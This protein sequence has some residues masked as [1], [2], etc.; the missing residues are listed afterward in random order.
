MKTYVFL[1]V[2][3]A[4]FLAA[5]GGGAPP[6][7]SSITLT[8][9]DPMGSF[10][11]A[12]YQV[13][14]GPWQSLT[15]SGMATK[16][17]TFGLGAQ[18]QYGVAVRCSGLVVKVIQATASE[19]PN[20]KLEC[21][22]SAPSTVPFTVNVNV[23][24]SLLAPGDAVCVHRP[25]GSPTCVPAT[26]SSSITCH[27]V[28]GSQDFLVSLQDS[29]G[30]VKVAK[31]LRNVVVNSGGNATV[32]LAPGDQLPPVGLTLPTPPTGYAPLSGALVSY[33]SF[34]NTGGGFVN[35]SL[36]SYRPVSGFSTGDR[37]ATLIQTAATNASLRSIQV[38]NSGS[39]S[40]SLPAPWAAG[41]LSVNQQAHPTVNGL[42]RSDPDLRGYE[43]YLQIAGQIY[44]TAILT[45]DWLGSTTSYTFPDLSAS[46]LLGYTPP[47]GSGSLKIS[48]NWSN[49]N[50]FA[51]NLTNFQAGDY[52]KVAE[53]Q[54]NYT[55]GG[56]TI[57]LP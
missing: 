24:A 28:S 15:M 2:L 41:S 14:S 16:T 3:L 52:L 20:P 18:S 4:L 33:L 39:P 32:N 8:V 57:T 19:L 23:D 13:G 42:S 43:L 46:G 34:S 49:K 17:G 7:P 9:E 6:P 12:A 47:T 38:F 50:L 30:S 53:A 27:A 10:N 1:S 56:G 44:Y 22:S 25:S 51:L 54:T 36:T 37:Y 21:S 40:L 5:C 48:A 35:V 29:A 26:T 45:K 55:V 11:A 31:V